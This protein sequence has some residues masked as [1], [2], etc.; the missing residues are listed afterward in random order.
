L[1]C[2]AASATWPAWRG[3]SLEFIAP[4]ARKKNVKLRESLEPVT[5]RG[6][7]SRLGQV[8]INLLSNAIQHNA[9]GVEVALS[10]Q[11]GGPGAVLRVADNGRGIPAEALPL[12]FDR[13]Y[14][15]DASRSRASG[16]NGLGLA[17][18]KAI[19]EA[20]GGTIRAQSQP[21]RGAEF[22]VEL[23]VETVGRNRVF[24]ASFF[25]FTFS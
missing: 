15:V 24:S 18:S 8:I 25:L 5:V 1:N 3:K 20:H 17:I 12:L 16:N 9:E 11:R 22:I 2:N 13:F 21:G 6:D 19:V 14:R 10:V 23:P 4:L 7:A